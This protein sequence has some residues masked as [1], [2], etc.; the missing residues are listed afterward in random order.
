[1]LA[2]RNWALVGESWLEATRY[3]TTAKEMIASQPITNPRRLYPFMGADEA[4]W[5]GVRAKPGKLINHK[6]GS[7]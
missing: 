3:P 4:E 2:S 5:A 6:S 1:M 7:G